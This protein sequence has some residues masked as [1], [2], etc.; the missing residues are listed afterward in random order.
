MRVR[1]DRK[2]ID[3]YDVAVVP[4][5]NCRDSKL[6]VKANMPDGQFSAMSRLVNEA[7]SRARLLFKKSLRGFQLK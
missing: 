4:I 7:Q 3:R 1:L 2:R 6:T 5:R